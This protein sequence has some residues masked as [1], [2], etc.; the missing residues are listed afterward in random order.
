MAIGM[1]V[2]PT[3]MRSS[4]GTTPGTSTPSTMPTAIATKIQSVR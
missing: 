2:V 1:E 3:D 4:T